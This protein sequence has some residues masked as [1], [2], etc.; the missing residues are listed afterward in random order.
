MEHKD[1]G[2]EGQNKKPEETI[3]LNTSL[4][5]MAFDKKKESDAQEQQELQELRERADLADVELMNARDTAEVV[6]K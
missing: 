1:P 2:R 6:S 4:I 3:I 5:Q